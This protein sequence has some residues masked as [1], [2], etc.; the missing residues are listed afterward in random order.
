MPHLPLELRRYLP[1]FHRFICLWGFADYVAISGCRSL[2]QSLADTFNDL[3]MV[4]NPRFAV[5]LSIKDKYFRFRQP[6]PVVGH[7]WNC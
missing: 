4:V 2:L 3:Y 5:R 6:F 7:Y 1:Q